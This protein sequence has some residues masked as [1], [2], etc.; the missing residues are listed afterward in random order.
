M[1]P[2]QRWAQLSAQLGANS[3]RHHIRNPFKFFVHI[4]LRFLVQ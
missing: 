1:S 2:A 4:G 3:S